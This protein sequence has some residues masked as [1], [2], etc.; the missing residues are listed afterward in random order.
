M[1]TNIRI[2]FLIARSRINSS[3]KCSIR[4]RV[5]YE[6][7]RYE[8]STGIFINPNFWSASRQ[9]ANPQD[10]EHTQINTQ[11]SLIKQELDQA[12][13]LLQIQDNR[14]NVDIHGYY[15]KKQDRGLSK[16]VLS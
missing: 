11:L 5:T 3:G 8:F 6:Q 10:T 1:N 15:K 13:L 2:L 4:C 7:K 16:L 14:F 9:K 12:F